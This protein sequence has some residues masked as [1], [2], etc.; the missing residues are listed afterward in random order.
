MRLETENRKKVY[1]AFIEVFE[2]ATG[3]AFKWQKG[4][5]GRVKQIFIRVAESMGVRDE[6]DFPRVLTVYRKYLIHAAEKWLCWDKR[7]RNNYVGFLDKKD[8]IAIFVSGDKA[9]KKFKG[10]SNDIAGTKDADE[11]DF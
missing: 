5:K 10:Q 7:D 8:N 11:W 1:D 6:E 2:A 3:T 4:E 9:G